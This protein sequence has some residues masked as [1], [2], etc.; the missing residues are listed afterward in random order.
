MAG[1]QPE[2]AS[3]SPGSAQSAGETFRDCPNCPQMVVIPAGSFRMGCLSNDDCWET[4][5]PVHDVT[6]RTFALSKYEATWDEWEA[7]VAAGGC[8]VHLADWGQPRGTRPVVIVSWKN[9]Q[10]YAAWLSA[11]TGEQYRLPTESEWEYAARAGTET[12]YS[13]GNGIGNNRASCNG[14][15]SQWDF[16]IG[17]A[18]VGSFE[19]NAFGLHDMH[20]NMA[21]FV[22]DCWNDSYAGVPADGSA[23][24]SDDCSDRVLRG[25]SRFG[26]P[27]NVCSACRSTYVSMGAG[28]GF[29]VARTLAP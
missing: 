15:G 3:D 10:S 18:P 14:C 7:C 29:R 21:E 23:W 17:G 4:Q 24:R 12:T 11:E 20:G 8:N 27:E 26:F 6:I 22:E 2:A 1:E 19:A 16:S 25:G 5:L 13:W 28:L 9:A